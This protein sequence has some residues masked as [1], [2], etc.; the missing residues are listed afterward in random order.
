[1]MSRTAPLT[2]PLYFAFFFPISEL[3]NSWD[4]ALAKTARAWARKCN[5]NHNNYLEEKGKVHP[6]FSPVGEN[7]WVGR[8]PQSFNASKAIQSFYSEVTAYSYQANSC[9]S[10]CGHYT[11]ELLKQIYEDSH[12]NVCEK[13]PV[14]VV[15]EKDM[16]L[17]VDPE[18]PTNFS[19]IRSESSSIIVYWDGPLHGG[20]SWFNLTVLLYNPSLDIYVPM[21]QPFEYPDHSMEV[22]VG[23]LPPCSKVRFN[24]ETIC[25]A[26]EI[27]HSEKISLDGST[28]PGTVSHLH[29]DQLQTK[30]SWKTQSGPSVTFRFRLFDGMHNIVKNGSRKHPQ[31]YLHNLRPGSFYE[32]EVQ[33]TC[34]NLEGHSS[35][36]EFHTEETGSSL[37][38][39]D[40]KHV[41]LEPSFSLMLP[42]A[43]PDYLQEDSSKSRELFE[44]YTE[45][46][47]ENIF[48]SY[49]NASRV[50]ITLEDFT[51]RENKTEINFQ[52]RVFFDDASSILSDVEEWE[53][54]KSL[55]LPYIADLK[56]GTLYW[57][58]TDECASFQLN[59]CDDNSH[60]INTLDSFACVCQDGFYGVKDPTK[61]DEKE[62]CDGSGMYVHCELDLMKVAVSKEFVRE[63]VTEDASLMLNDGSCPLQEAEK[64]FFFIENDTHVVFEHT[65]HADV[66]V[67]QIITRSDLMMIWRCIFPRNYL[68]HTFIGQVQNDRPVS[69][70][71]IEHN[72]TEILKLSMTL[73]KRSTFDPDYFNIGEINYSPSS[74]LFF[75]GLL[76]GSEV[77][78]E[79]GSM[80]SSTKSHDVSAQDVEDKKRKKKGDEAQ[81][82]YTNCVITLRYILLSTVICPMEDRTVL[83][84]VDILRDI[85]VKADL[86]L[87]EGSMTVSTTKKTFD[88][89]SIIKARDLIKLLARSVPFEQAMRILQDD[90]AC[91][92]IKIGS[93]V[94]NR[95]SFVK[96]RQRLIGPKGST[97]KALELLTNCYVMVQGN[98]VSALGPYGGLKETLMIKRELSKDP[99]LR[100]QSWER[101]LPNFKPKNLSKRKAPKKKVVKKEYTPFPPPQP[102]SQVDKELASGEFFLKESQKRRK[103]IEEIK[104]KQAEALSKRQE[105]RQKAFIPPK[106]KAVVKKQ[107]VAISDKIDVQAIKEKVKKAKNKKLGA[108]PVAEVAQM[109]TANGKKKKKTMHH[110]GVGFHPLYINPEET[111]GKSF[112]GMQ[113]MKKSV[114]QELKTEKQKSSSKGLVFTLMPLYAIGVGIFAAYK[115]IK[116]RSQNNQGRRKNENSEMNKNSE[117]TGPPA[118]NKLDDLIEFPV[119][120][121]KISH[122]DV[123]WEAI[124]GQENGIAETG[125]EDIVNDDLT[126]EE[127]LYTNDET[128]DMDLKSC[129]NVNLDSMDVI[130]DLPEETEETGLRRRNK[131]DEH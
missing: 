113:D 57:N 80:A 3:E 76:A 93:L 95:E 114:D 28:G 53:H 59:N 63:N 77:E 65:L 117:E 106:E 116:I 67:G 24:L 44:K 100:M 36:L 48:S 121:E 83:T 98:T 101:F 12:I 110:F 23:N 22:K 25:D 84:V 37:F 99:E 123:D 14:Y 43:L 81:H 103:K 127:S 66:R 73:Y 78:G 74:D 42:W 71:V 109:N 64:Y 62:I 88:P 4:E 70:I 115:F 5:F 2:P 33:E 112:E 125:T 130:K 122:S 1:M 89:Y 108:P 27:T 79:F 96:R 51:K 91:D 18:K 68:L 45:K 61:P 54:I 92:I 90:V 49:K 17:L 39:D 6:V 126:N 86:D 87:I 119:T 8:P 85:N 46:Q 60:C 118:E 120:N 16:V 35:F 38:E 72:T 30:A 50:D 124:A 58:D 105:E 107:A 104:V 7:I 10:V 75:E 15:D 82:S 32:L 9:T 69:V 31:L 20:F 41:S 29:F 13:E 111:K 11:Q 56:N 21:D 129:S 34:F 40:Q 102:E 26:G 52:V 97:L 55:N 94:R 131:H 47:L 128:F 19:I